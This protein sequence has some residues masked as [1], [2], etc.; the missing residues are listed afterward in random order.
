MSK[1]DASMISCIFPCQITSNIIA[2]C[3]ITDEMYKKM[4]KKGNLIS[5]SRKS[6]PPFFPHT[7]RNAGHNVIRIQCTYYC[8]SHISFLSQIIL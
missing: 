1:K 5:I 6:Y 4:E 8:F 7:S 3:C 2:N